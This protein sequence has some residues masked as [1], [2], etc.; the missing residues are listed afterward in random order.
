MIRGSVEAE[1]AQTGV[2]IALTSDDKKPTSRRS[3]RPSKVK[4]ISNREDVDQDPALDDSPR[5]NREDIS[6][7]AGQDETLDPGPPEPKS[8]RPQLSPP[9]PGIGWK[10]GKNATASRPR[11]SEV[12]SDAASSDLPAPRRKVSKDQV[13]AVTD[14]DTNPLPPAIDPD[15]PDSDDPAPARPATARPRSNKVGAKGTRKPTESGEIALVTDASLDEESG[16][17]KPPA[18]KASDPSL[19]AGFQPLSTL[20]PDLDPAPSTPPGSS[21]IAKAETPTLS[22]PPAL[23]PMTPAPSGEPIQV[24]THEAPTPTSSPP[25]ITA[26]SQP[27]APPKPAPQPAFASNAPASK[28]VE[29]PTPPDEYNPFAKLPPTSLPIDRVVENPPLVTPTSSE[30]PPSPAAEHPKAKWG[31]LAAS[32]RPA[33]APAPVA[34]TPRTTLTSVLFRRAKPPAE[35]K[36]AAVAAC[37][38]DTRLRKINDFRLPDLEGKPVRFQDLDAD[39]VLLD[40]WGTWCAL[41][42]T[43]SRTWSNSRSSMGQA[44]SR[45]SGSPAS[46]PRLNRGGRRWTR[47]LGGLGSTTPCCSRRWTASR[48]RSSRRSRSRRCR[49]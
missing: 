28:A 17:E 11:N 13:P 43:P 21:E 12:E 19:V 1:T 32:E 39:F 4:P 34:P 2:E 3:A 31:E 38:Y 49:R 23:P 25:D 44:S 15:T 48:A 30:V 8:A 33:P 14:E 41:A 5:I 22:E 18:K 7:S 35:S 29:K 6:A 10:N 46:R 47:S 36:D 37:V 26:A 16:P 45:W 40:F 9:D 42:S 20:M 27:D 24:A